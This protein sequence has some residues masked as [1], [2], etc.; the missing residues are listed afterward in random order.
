MKEKNEWFGIV[1]WC[2]EDLKAALENNGYPVNDNNVDELFVH[3]QHHSFTDY[4]ISAGWDFIDNTISE[5]AF[6]GKI[7][8]YGE[9]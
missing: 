1:R 7:E 5:L 9:E 4:M 2:K 3:L 6:D 8:E